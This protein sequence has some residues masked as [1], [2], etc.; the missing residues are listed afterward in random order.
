MRTEADVVIAGAGL[1]GLSAAREVAAAGRSVLVVEARDRVGG[2]TVGH[3]LRNGATVEMGGQWVG[4]GQTEV[5]DLVRELG[6]ETFATYDDGAGILARDG[7]VHRYEDETL[8][9]PEASLAEIGRVQ[10]ILE[11]LAADILPASPWA[12][13][14]SRE[15][16]RQTFDSWLTAQT[17]QTHGLAY[18]RMLARALF[19]AEAAELSLLHVLF[20]VA[21]AGGIDALTLTTGG[22]QER[23]VVGGS[24]RIS[25]RLAEDLG[26]DAV[27]LGWP[28]QSIVQ[29]AESVTVIG[30]GSE[31]IA[32][33][34]I[35][36]LPPTLAGRLRYAPPL[37]ASRDGL[38][39]QMPMGTVIKVQ[40]AYET[41]FWRSEGLSGQALSFDD[42]L[43]VTFDNS[44]PDGSCG[45]LLGFLEAG[46]GRDAARLEPAARRDLVLGILAKFF[47]EAAARPIEYVERD[48]AAEEF[49]RGCYGGRLGA[50]AWT[51]YGRALV[52]PVGRIH[53]AGAESSDVWNG[54]MDGA[55]RSGRRAA[56]EALAGLDR[57]D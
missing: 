42:P 22:A 31:V 10:A 14:Q 25:D 21:S 56:R 43:E 44:P 23:R 49:T 55:V 57:S 18:F 50:G 7:G 2:R 53:W 13:T 26:P 15:L 47:G 17:D 34:V 1:A 24:H 33:Q 51:A 16:D 19:S 29:D 39:Q 5:L 3:R 28:V 38:T 46:H 30:Y 12:A 35:V 27:A 11:G 32:R 52:E 48:W 40:A 20:Y 8:G 54:Y 45:V 9:L 41:P 6:L 36:A 4:P 37:P